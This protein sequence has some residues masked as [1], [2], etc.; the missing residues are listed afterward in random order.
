MGAAEALAKEGVSVEVIDLRTLRP[1]DME[2]IRRSVRKTHRVVTVE[3]SWPYGG[4]GAELAYRVQSELFDELD[5]P[6]TR[7]TS[8]DVP[9]PYA[10]NLEHLVLPNVADVVSAINAVTYRS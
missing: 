9:M 10:E 2:T 6:V 7:V 8:L 5:A 4:I 1:L 3:E